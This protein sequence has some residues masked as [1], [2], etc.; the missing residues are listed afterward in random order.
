[1][2]AKHIGDRWRA[3]RNFETSPASTRQT[4]T[5]SRVGRE[6]TS[7]AGPARRLGRA[8]EGLLCRV[9]ELASKVAA[10][11]LDL[12][13]K[14]T[15]GAKGLAK[16]VSEE[17]SGLAMA[18]ADFTVK[19]G[20]MPPVRMTARL[21]VYP[22][23]SWCTR[24]RMGSM[25]SNSASPHRGT[26]VLPLTKSASGG[27]LSRVM[28]ALEVVLAGSG[29]GVTMVSTRSM[30]ASVGVRRSRSVVDWRGLP[31]VIR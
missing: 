6:V 14:R 7:P 12:S 25:S 1:M 3:R 21:C 22:P 27:E 29:Q 16:A 9:D 30:P 15:K 28:L 24:E 11:A 5:G 26:D 31:A 20:L 19:V 23:A 18:D 8:L 4:S 10:T 13:K 17:L 2:D